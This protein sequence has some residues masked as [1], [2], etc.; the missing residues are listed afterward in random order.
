MMLKGSR[1]NCFEKNVVLL[2]FS[3][4]QNRK[5]QYINDCSLVLSVIMLK[6]QRTFISMLLLSLGRL[7]I[8]F[9]FILFYFILFY[10]IF[11]LSLRTCLL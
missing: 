7:R 9:Y 4:G 8:L 11:F 1:I 10:F 2:L 3:A 5:R 6:C